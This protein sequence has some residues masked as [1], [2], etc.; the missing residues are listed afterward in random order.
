MKTEN[1]ESKRNGS[2]APSESSS[3]TE[4][5][6][7]SRWK[8]V[9]SLGEKLV[10][11]LGFE[12]GVDTLGRWMS[13]HV[14]ELMTQ[15]A[16][17]EGQ[18]QLQARKSCEEAILGLWAHRAALPGTQPLSEFNPVFAVLRFLRGRN[19][20]FMQVPDTDDE[21]L[22]VAL[23]ASA[24][25]KELVRL[26]IAAAMS[27]AASKEEEWLKHGVRFGKDD[28]DIRGI[29]IVLR[30]IQAEGESPDGGTMTEKQK[31]LQTA[32]R[33]ETA[34][35]RLSTLAQQT[36]ARIRLEAEGN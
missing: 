33:L 17:A 13:H 27:S 12:S 19:P 18:E 21:C 22:K 24:L 5:E 15:A 11:E 30:L 1:G 7:S 35:E 16:E 14:A 29:R 3:S 26:S 31:R 25:S 23:S 4:T 10:E 28:D 8:D 32:E 36:A 2:P 9:V 34:A 6:H 20:Y